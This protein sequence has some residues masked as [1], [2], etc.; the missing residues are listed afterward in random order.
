MKPERAF[1]YWFDFGDDWYHQV[2][3]ERIEQA[4]STVT[5]PRVIKR[6]GN[7][8]NV[9]EANGDRTTW[10]YDADYRLTNEHRSGETSYNITH[11]Y[12]PV[13]NRL[14]KNAADAL[15]TYSYDVANQ[16]QTS[17]DA[18]GITTYTFDTSG[19]QQ[20]VEMPNAT[21]I[22]NTWDDENRLVKVLLPDGRI[23]TN[24]YR[25]DGLRFQK[26]DSSGT[27][28]FIYDGQ[29]YLAENDGNGATKAV[30]TNEPQPYG[31]LISQRRQE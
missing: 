20:I 13:G 6:V 3:V 12:D 5:Y 2:Q 21:R 10:T 29:N 1:G 27:T 14:V 24:I 19:N 4:I 22:T 8:K 26:Q 23:T 15:T 16:L 7:R 17:R 11:V 31:K 25:A 28:R 18:T 9:L 30:Y